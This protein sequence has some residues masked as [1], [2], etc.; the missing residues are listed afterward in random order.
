MQ[1]H[2]YILSRFCYKDQIDYLRGSLNITQIRYPIPKNPTA[3]NQARF[4]VI[5]TGTNLANKN[6]HATT[7]IL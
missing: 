7:V 3:T 6:A 2:Y 4:I 1:A 5:I